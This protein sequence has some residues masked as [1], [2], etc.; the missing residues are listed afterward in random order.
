[1]AAMPHDPERDL[2]AIVDLMV[3]YQ[4]QLPPDLYP[5]SDPAF[6][7]QQL[8]EAYQGGGLVYA[9][10]WDGERAK[11]CLVLALYNAFWSPAHLGA[12]DMI[13]YVRPAYRGRTG[14]RL[15]KEAEAKAKAAGATRIEMNNVAPEHFASVDKLYRH[16]GY[17][18]TCTTYEKGL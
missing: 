5:D 3:E 7:F 15:I 4:A 18:P 1:M 12:N 10:E 17:V 11:G 2:Q 9:I 13:F 16:L 14:L 6:A 8:A